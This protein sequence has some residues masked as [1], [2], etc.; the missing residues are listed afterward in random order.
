MKHSNIHFQKF[1]ISYTNTRSTATIQIVLFGYYSYKPDIR[2]IG[3]QVIPI[4]L[5][6]LVQIFRPEKTLVDFR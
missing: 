5:K 6:A 2:I 4:I 1:F 3:F